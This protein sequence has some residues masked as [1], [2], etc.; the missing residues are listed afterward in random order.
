MRQPDLDREAFATVIFTEALDSYPLSL[1]GIKLQGADWEGGRD[2]PGLVFSGGEVVV[3]RGPRSG[4]QE[5]NHVSGSVSGSGTQ[6][7]PPWSQPGESD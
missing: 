6:S 4:V 7:S 3:V 1:S 2:Q 5:A